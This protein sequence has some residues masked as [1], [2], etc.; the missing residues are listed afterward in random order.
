MEVIEE[1]ILLFS[2]GRHVPK[3]GKLRIAAAMT[4]VRNFIVKELQK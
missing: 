2:A 1:Y 4:G 3:Y